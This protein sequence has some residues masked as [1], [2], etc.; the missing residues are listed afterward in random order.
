MPRFTL[1]DPR[2]L[3]ILF[4]IA[5]V[6]LFASSLFMRAWSYND[7]VAE[8]ILTGFDCLLAPTHHP[9]TLLNPAWWAN[10]V[11]AVT[12]VALFSNQRE[13]A[14]SCGIIAFLLA[15]LCI[16]YSWSDV[17]QV[18]LAIPLGGIYQAQ[19]GVYLW[20]SAIAT[21]ACSI[22]VLCWLESASRD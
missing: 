5:A 7:L 22:P 3:S 21:V 18:L 10:P 20:F 12:V 9:T 16:A 8:H 17:S 2:R 11:F 14:S 15:F 4:A 1:R 19:I 13:R 6:T